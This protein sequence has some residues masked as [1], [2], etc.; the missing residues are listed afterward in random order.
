MFVNYNDIQQ[1]IYH[2]LTYKAR[3]RDE[4]GVKE[5]RAEEG[6]KTQILSCKRRWLDEHDTDVIDT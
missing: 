5:M 6:T 4:V 3:A 1:F 2:Q